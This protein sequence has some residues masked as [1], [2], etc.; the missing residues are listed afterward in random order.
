RAL[1]LM[2]KLPVSFLRRQKNLLKADANT[3]I[4]IL[5][6]FHFPL[7]LL[8]TILS[9][10]HWECY[11][12]MQRE[13]IQVPTQWDVQKNFYIILAKNALQ[14]RIRLGASSCT[15]FP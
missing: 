14:K 6:M 5:R 2:E 9:T 13:P 1:G 8:T 15:S 7:L 10:I 11:L 12:P 3:P 4:F